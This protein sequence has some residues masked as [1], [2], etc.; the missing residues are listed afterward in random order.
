MNSPEQLEISQI[1][2]RFSRLRLTNPRDM[3]RLQELVGNEG[4]IRDP[5]LVSTAVEPGHLV[6]VDGF[7]RLRVAQ[8]R[9]LAHLW[10]HSAQLDAAH[11]LAAIVHCNQPREGLSKLEEAWI[12]RSLCHEHALMQI[13]VAELLN[14][15]K[16]WVCRRLK[17]ARALDESVQNDVRRGALCATTACELSQ[18]QRCNQQPVARAVI[19]HDLSLGECKQLLKKLQGT[20]DQ[21]AAREVLDDPRRYIDPT[22]SRTGRT[23]GSDPHLSKDGNRLRSALLNWQRDCSRLT[24]EL[25]RAS[26]ADTRVLAPM[27]EDAFIAG[28][29]A[30]RQLESAHS[31]SSVNLP[32]KQD[33]PASGPPAP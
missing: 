1:D 2:P 19:E 9:G 31:S 16:T 6:L 12:V 22:N 5:V 30:V 14:R 20:R 3:R 13:K 11:A 21:D 23:S 32:P 25:R 24:D 18:L 29:R 33:E 10:V 28:T 27:I 8:E 7:K 17:L 15:D 4:E 26:A